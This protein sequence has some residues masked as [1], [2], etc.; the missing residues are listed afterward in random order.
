MSEY[1]AKLT[2]QILADPQAIPNT[3]YNK[4]Y[5]LDAGQIYLIISCWLE[6]IIHFAP[7]LRKLQGMHIY[8]LIRD[9]PKNHTELFGYLRIYLYKL[10]SHYLTVLLAMDAYKYIPYL[11]SNLHKLPQ[12]RIEFLQQA[13]NIPEYFAYINSPYEPVIYYNL[14]PDKIN[15]LPEFKKIKLIKLMHK[16]IEFIKKE[17]SY[18]KNIAINL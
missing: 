17:N 16:Y 2:E 13:S 12:E 10:S 4:L 11:R 15:A 6:Y 7:Y 9:Y 14:Y 18:G 3:F 1:A 5:L 8:Y